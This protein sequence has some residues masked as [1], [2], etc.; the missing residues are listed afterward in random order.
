MKKI[1]IEMSTFRR[2][3]EWVLMLIGALPF[4]YVLFS[5]AVII[6][7]VIIIRLGL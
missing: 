2:L 7:Q 3:V 4:L 1:E 5:I 6:M